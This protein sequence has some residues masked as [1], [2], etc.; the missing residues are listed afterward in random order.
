MKIISIS[1]SMGELWNLMY[2][3]TIIQD[4]GSKNRSKHSFT[5]FSFVTISFPLITSPFSFY[6]CASSSVQWSWAYFLFWASYSL[7]WAMTALLSSISSCSIWIDYCLLFL[8]KSVFEIIYFS[9]CSLMTA[10]YSFFF[11]Y[12]S[13]CSSLPSAGPK[14]GITN[15]FLSAFSWARV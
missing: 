11:L 3:K 4:S 7:D 6:F 13:I 2:F 8:V 12:L 14:C 5:H 10:C 1:I 15:S 9:R